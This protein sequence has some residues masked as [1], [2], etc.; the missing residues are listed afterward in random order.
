MWNQSKSLALSILVTR[1]F[2]AAIGAALFWLP[3]LGGHYLSWRGM[4]VV[5]L[6]QLILPLYLCAVPAAIALVCL[7]RLLAR[8]KK[9]EVF[10]NSNVLAIRII[11]WCCFA[12][13]L[14]TAVSVYFYLPFVF[15]AVI[16][17]FCGLIV[18]VIKNVI[19]KAVLIK[20]ENDYTI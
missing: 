20:N 13:C 5:T 4:T 8:I 9:D 17:F 10:V 1:L 16:M 11:S 2:M 6:W 14:V 15:I 12:V 18:R 3:Y 19:A 7:D